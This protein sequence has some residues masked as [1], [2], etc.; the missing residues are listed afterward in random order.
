MPFDKN[1]FRNREIIFVNEESFGVTRTH[2]FTKKHSWALRWG[3]VQAIEAMQIEPATIGLI[4]VVAG[5]EAR[6][7]HEDMENWG[8]LETAARKRY[9]EFNWENFELAKNYVERRIPCW[10]RPAM[11]SVA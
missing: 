1:L 7:A 9:A 8:E 4:F 2:W 6:N 11:A 3:D 5:N 10:K